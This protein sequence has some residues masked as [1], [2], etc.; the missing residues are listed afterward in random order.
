VVVLGKNRLAVE[1][2]PIIQASGDE[3]VLAMPEPSDDGTDGWQ[4][5]FRAA[6]EAA[7]FPIRQAADLNAPEVI[8]AVRALSPDFLLSFQAGQILRSALISVPAHGS[9]NLHFGSL[10]RYRGVAPIA[11]ALLNGERS[12]GATL[13]RIDTGV[14]SGAIVATAE[15]PIERDDTGRSLYDKVTEAGIGLF[16]EWWP[17]LRGGTV[18]TRSQENGEVLY[19]NRH[20]I[21]FS[22]RVLDW[23]H[24][25]E[26][27]ANQARALIF[28]PFQYPVV[29][30]GEL[31]LELRRFRWDREPHR[32]RPGEIL[33]AVGATIVV[34]AP[35]GRLLLDELVRDGRTVLVRD[36]EELG[37][38]AGAILSST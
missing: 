26:R 34:G 15:V 2:A 14:D 6:A 18:E 30:L 24:D 9:W 22:Q 1:C 19:Y 32:G 25:C 29:R 3:I 13:H 21:D 20:S 10:P 36:H 27:I 7:G 11:W 8:D 35:G 23:R 4:P 33:A 28:P 17:R 37:L 31:E 16:R 12:T 5:S 38:V